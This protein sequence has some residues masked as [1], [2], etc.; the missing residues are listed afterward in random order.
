MGRII[1]HEGAVAMRMQRG[2]VQGLKAFAR[3]EVTWAEVEGMTFEEAKAIA[4]VGCDLAAAGRLEEARILFEGLVEG[5]PKDAAAR[6]A[7]GTV[8]QKLGKL[9][10][11]IAEYSAALEREP[12]NPVALANRGELYL[13]RGERQGFTDLANAV[14]ADPHGETAGGRRARALVKAITLVA[15]E[16]LKEDSQP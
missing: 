9:D 3:G 8:Y 10:D 6:A 1:K 13:R 4:Q 2:A 7:L 12:D 11:A 14:E 15:V 16:K 5:N